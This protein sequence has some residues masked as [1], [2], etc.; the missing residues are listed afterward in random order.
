MA[1]DPLR[2]TLRL[3]SIDD[4][5]DEPDLSPFDPYYAQYSFAAGMDY[6]VG[7]MQRSPGAKRTELT[8]LLPPDQIDPGLEERTR[9]AIDRYATAW[10]ASARQTR[11]VERYKTFRVA[12]VALLVFF[13]ANFLYLRYGQTGSILGAS[14]ILTDVLVEGLSIASWVVLWWP[15]DQLLH[16]GWQHYLDE[17]A[18]HA[19]KDINLRILP[20]PNPPT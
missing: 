1:K 11:E 9:V 5:F 10:G 8:V 2:V 14:G 18:Y 6:L 3:K 15:L 7:E 17:R 12:G 16:V 13:I 4:L 20:D 19:L